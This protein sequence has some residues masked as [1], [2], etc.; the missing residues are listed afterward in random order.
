MKRLFAGLIAVVAVAGFVGCDKG[1][2]G[3]AGVT[4]T[5][6]RG[7]HV[8]QAEDTFSLTV[9]T[10]STHLKQGEA[11]VVAIGISR[12]KNFDGDVAVGFDNLPKGV[13]VDPAAPALKHGEKE[14]KVTV[15][16]ADDAALGDFAVKVVGHP[17][18]GPDAT[19]ELKL[20]VEKK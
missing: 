7:P 1:T 5:G 6:D 2:P 9:P 14:V 20:T 16:A 12:G 17:A 18:K 8:G 13:T 15:K 4:T 19:N 3:G 11:K 10:L